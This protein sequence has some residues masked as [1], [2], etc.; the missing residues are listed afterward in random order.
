MRDNCLGTQMPYN[1]TP[2]TELPPPKGY[3]P[4]YINYIGRHCGRYLSNKEEA[5]WICTILG[6]AYEHQGLT[7]RGLELLSK[8][9][10]ILELS[11][12]QEENL[13]P[14]G[15]KALEGI[16]SRMTLNYPTV[17]G[18]IMNLTATKELRT[19]KSRDIFLK[20]LNRHIESDRVL[21]HTN[22][23]FDPILRFFDWNEPYQRW[24][25]QGEWK[26]ILSEF[27]KRSEIPN[28]ILERIFHNEFF[29]YHCLNEEE[30]QRFLSELFQIYTNQVDTSGVIS[31]GYYF[32]PQEKL[33]YWEN[34]NL[35]QYL[36]MGP[37]LLTQGTGGRIAFP[38]LIDFLD[39]VEEAIQTR[40]TSADMIFA[41]AETMLPFL[42][43]LQ[44]PGMCERTDSPYK[45]A[46]TWKNY[47]L[48]PMAANLQWIFYEKEDGST[49]DVLVQCKL[50]EETIRLPIPTAMFPYYRWS[51]VYEYFMR[52]LQGLNLP[53]GKKTADVIREYQ[54]DECKKL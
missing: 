20:E 4:F 18:K 16:A 25:K 51:E 12:K 45:V 13:N 30:K 41:H 23:T 39:T 2:E 11:E 3:T 42:A 1:Y 52:I 31:L 47:Q 28:R 49:Q 43:L 15:V 53:Q 54:W 5:E 37:G 50:N 26:T 44:L 33:Y 8:L 17:F 35:K 24:K 32:T 29:R 21:I 38:L 7:I 27:E 14:I 40:R 36:L 34:T 19:Q 10:H 22:G 6:C 9:I 46:I 48:M